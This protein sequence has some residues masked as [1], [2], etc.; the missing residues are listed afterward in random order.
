M[1][2]VDCCRVAIV[3]GLCV[4][5]NTSMVYPT[6]P[7]QEDRAE[8]KESTA[9]KRTNKVSISVHALMYDG[10]SFRETWMW[11]QRRGIQGGTWGILGIE[12][13]SGLGTY[14]QPTS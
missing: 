4:V 8:P 11:I 14:F 6:Q 13:I 5:E 1:V 7:T 3:A 9:T 12:E 10:P 2:E